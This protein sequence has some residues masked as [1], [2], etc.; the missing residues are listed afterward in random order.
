MGRASGT[1][2][3]RQGVSMSSWTVAP[4]SRQTSMH[5]SRLQ[6]PAIRQ[7]RYGHHTLPLYSISSV[8]TLKVPCTEFSPALDGRASLG[9]L[10]PKSLFISCV[11]V[12]GLISRSCQRQSRELM[13]D[14]THMEMAWARNKRSAFVST[15]RFLA[16]HAAQSWWAKPLASLVIVC[17][18]RITVQ[19]QSN[20]YFVFVAFLLVRRQ[21]M[22]V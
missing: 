4:D 20:A 13:G 11:V 16:L 8:Q 2:G 22:T 18:G 5:I 12:S 7:S 17:K 6:T 21:T 1:L 9:T 15:E 19:T 14:P 3:G 10:P